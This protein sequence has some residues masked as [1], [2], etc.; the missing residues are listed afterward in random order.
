MLYSLHEYAYY[1]AAPYRALAQMTRDFWG[2][3]MNPASDT[4][5]GRTLYASAELFS[6]VTLRYCK[7]E[8][9]LDHLAHNGVDVRVNIIEDW[10]SPWVK[11]LRFQRDN[12]DL[13]RA[14][15]TAAAP[16][17]LIVA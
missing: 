15:K 17:V 13:R 5:I 10:Q 1:T 12:S 4:A 7:P 16:A 6:N 14:G 3:K 9:G 11:L 8:W 2:S